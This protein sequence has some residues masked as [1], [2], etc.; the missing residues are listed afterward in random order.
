V[1]IDPKILIDDNW[2]AC[3]QLGTDLRARSYAGVIAPSAALPGS[4]GLV[5]FRPQLMKPFNTTPRLSGSVPAE[6][7]AIG[8]PGPGLTSRVRYVGD[9]HAEWEAYRARTAVKVRRPKGGSA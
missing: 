7:I 3:Q 5:G 6:T 9:K 4:C 2:G 1:G 8:R